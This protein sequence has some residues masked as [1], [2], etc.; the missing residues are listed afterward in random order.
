MDILSSDILSR[1]QVILGYLILISK[2]FE[3]KV[4]LG[5]LEEEYN[6]TKQNNFMNNQME[7]YLY[8]LYWVTN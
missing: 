5:N 3:W 7:N 1:G 6:T 2:L 4:Y 8:I